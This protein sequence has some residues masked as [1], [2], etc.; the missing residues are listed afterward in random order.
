MIE[1]KIHCVKVILLTVP[2]I[3]RDRMTCGDSSLGPCFAGLDF[4]GFRS[5]QCLLQEAKA[6]Y[7]QFFDEYGLPKEW[8]ASNPGGENGLIR[9][10]GNSTRSRCH[11]HLSG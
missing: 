9:Q 11:G 1:L 4:D 10:A 6:K 8:W 5:P 3:R 2:C 7:D